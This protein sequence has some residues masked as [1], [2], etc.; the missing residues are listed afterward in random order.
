MISDKIIGKVPP[1][2]IEAEKSIL[3]SMLLD[4]EA[5]DKS[6]ELLEDGFFY[7]ESHQKI[8]QSIVELYD[9]NSEVDIVTLIE[10]LRKRS[11]LEQIGGPAYIT[12]LV[13]EV[14]T[15]A[16]V[17][18][19]LK[20][21]REKYILRTLIKVATQIVSESYEPSCEIEELLDKAEQ[22]IFDIT[23]K[24]DKET[25]VFSIKEIVK[26]SIERID[27][28]Y[29]RKENVTGLP[30]G[31]HELDIM[32]A[33]LQ[34]SDFIVVAARPS[35]G[36]SAF[37]AS[38][39]GHIGMVQKIPCAFFSLEMSKEQ[40]VQ[41]FLCSVAHVNAQKVRTGFF[42]QSDWPKLMEAAD[43]LSKSPIFIDDTPSISL[44]EIRAKARRLKAQHNIQFIVI[45]YIQLIKTYGRIESRQQEISEIS[46]SIK[47]LARELRV[48]VIGISQ[49]SRAVEQR[50]DHRPMLSDLRES[51][52]IEQDADLVMLLLREEYYEPTEENKGIAEVIIAKQRNGPVG[53][54]KLAFLSEYTK[55]SN[56]SRMEEEEGF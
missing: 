39:G 19:Y 30:T 50:A 42:S 25:Q 24:S 5:I 48:P 36:K 4:R 32:T 8:Y 51:G 1:S 14:P 49:L 15:S 47:A 37:A 55:F 56:L 10:E 3:A 9:K 11:L 54:V 53:S 20:I 22:L 12:E 6:M 46:R 29:Q 7:L 41:R 18:H 21:V 16:N 23:S 27:S 34:P 2:S 26:I 35:M 45:D 38:I 28:L 52:A 40:L 13:N 44:L 43:K 17:E 33:G 31:F